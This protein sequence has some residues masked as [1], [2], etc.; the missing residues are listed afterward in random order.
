MTLPSLPL[1][2][3]DSRPEG[4]LMLTDFTSNSSDLGW[5][6]VNDN[7]MG[8]RSKGYFAQTQG[9]IN[10]EGRTNTNG[11]GFS[12]IRTS[13]LQLDLSSHVGIQLYVRGDGRRYIWQLAT[14]AR[15]R[16]RQV[17]YWADFDTGNGNW[18]IVNIP[19]SSFIPRYRGKQHSGP[20]LDP[21]QITGMGLM[22]YD[23]QDGPFKLSL[24]TVHAYSEDAPFT[25][26]QY[27]WKN[28]VLI[29]S[30][31]T[32]DDR[33]LIEQHDAVT[34]TRDEFASRDIVLVTLLDEEISTA[35]NRELT[36]GE[37][38]TAREALDIRPGSFA[39]R[40]IGK[41]G[42]IKFSGEV[43]TSMAEIF[44]LIDSMPMR[45]REMPDR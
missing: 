23:N 31:P 15:S 17:R 21:G 8:G 3:S 19:F 13:P 45:Q 10:F 12:S 41:D 27:Q 2:A 35:E 28:R 5:Y 29:V 32:E 37:T 33:N 4:E 7:V 24:A 25:L 40:L 22:I 38:V 34:L 18:N 36:T 42:S 9:E 6:M 30:A 11:G 14:A 20:A 26:M 16:G 39:L 1:A 43:A 44:A